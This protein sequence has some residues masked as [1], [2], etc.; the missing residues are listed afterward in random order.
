MTAS[1]TSYSE[2]IKYIVNYFSKLITSNQPVYFHC[3][4][5][6][7][8][9]GFAEAVYRIQKQNYNFQKAL[10]D[11][12]KFNYGEGISKETQ[13]FYNNI[14]K[15][16]SASTTKQVSF[17]ADDDLSN[18]D[19]VLTE[20]RSSFDTSHLDP[21][22][23][24]RSFSGLYETQQ[25]GPESSEH[26]I[27]PVGDRKLMIEKLKSNVLPNVGMN[28]GLGPARGFGPSQNSAI[29]SLIY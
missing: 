9:T 23:M 15:A 22:G 5:G 28:Y 14:L 6:Q 26:N 1:E 17:A 25:I 19:I 11:I 8:R 10:N 16:L 24:P 18:D 3:L 2:S 7:D 13:N 12:K 4:H 29:L 20:M 21:T 27:E